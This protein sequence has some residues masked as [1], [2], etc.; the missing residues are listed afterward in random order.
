MP[1][2]SRLVGRAPLQ[3]FLGRAHVATA[4]L[5]GVW[6]FWVFRMSGDMK[7]ACLNAFQ[8]VSLGVFW[9]FSSLGSRGKVY[10]RAV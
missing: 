9:F 10:S 5:Q 6:A 4:H 2:L 8:C 3:E 7:S 1:S